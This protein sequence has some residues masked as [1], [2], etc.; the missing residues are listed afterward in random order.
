[1][2]R[3]AHIGCAICASLLATYLGASAHAGPGPA[4]PPKV[5]EDAGGPATKGE[6][7]AVNKP[8]EAKKRPDGWAPGIAIGGTF[9]LMDTRNVV[10]SMDG[11]AVTLGAALDAALEFNAGIHEWR[12]SLLGAAGTTYTPSLGEFVK[13][14]DG[15]AF[16]SIYLLHAIEILGPY[17][18][19][20]FDTQMFP[21][22]DVRPS[23][24]DYE[25]SN[26]DGSTTS[27]NGR[28]LALTDP[29][30]PFN[31]KEGLGLFV[32]PLNQTQIHMEARA[33]FGA[34]ETLAKDNL[35]VTDDSSTPQIEAK[36]LDDFYQIGAEATF[37]VWGFFDTTKRVSYTA[38]IGVLVP[39]TTSALPPGDDRGLGELTDV[40]GTL[41]LNA[42]LFDWASLGYRLQVVR[43][44]MLVD[45]WQISN[46]V[47]ITIGAAF[48]S[49]APAPEPP[50][51]CDCPKPEEVKPAAQ[52][53][54]GP[55]AA[56]SAKAPTP[57]EPAA[58][59]AEPP[60]PAPPPAAPPTPPPAA[61]PAP[62]P[63]PGPVP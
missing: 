29:F 31:L 41:G 42:K 53:D 54:A 7:E 30:K 13:T 6:T 38:G 51:P 14:S 36:Q 47:L 48:G 40:E 10:G 18:R 39:F 63:A 34:Q 56:D 62:A 50:P 5:V 46:N 19:F 16:Q 55:A 21:G 26:L 11:T 23:A 9:N 58:K 60:A 12:N 24:V 8:D 37:N 4:A 2:R 32:Q 3:P 35:A 17:A 61:P 52:P 1:L 25:V 15:L 33:G 27:Y 20:A 22:M 49:K 57:T 43:Q 28:R 45:K 44:P 59:P